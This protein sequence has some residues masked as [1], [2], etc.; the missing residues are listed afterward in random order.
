VLAGTHNKFESRQHTEM[1][2]PALKTQ[3]E[4]KMELSPDRVS[5]F[6]LSA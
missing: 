2:L 4:G 5:F 6:I 3:D 1:Y